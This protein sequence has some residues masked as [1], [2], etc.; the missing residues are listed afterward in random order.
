LSDDEFLTR[1]LQRM[2]EKSK[3]QQEPLLNQLEM[4]DAILAEA[5]S[6]I[7][8]LVNEMAHHEGAVLDVFR[9]EV[10][11]TSREISALEAE[12]E[13]LRVL[14]AQVEITAEQQEQLTAAL[15]FVRGRLPDSSYENKR[16]L[17]KALDA[18]VIVFFEGENKRIKVSCRLPG[19]EEDIELDTSRKRKHRSGSLKR[20]GAWPMVKMAG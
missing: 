15:E 5:H 11:T 17:L 10:K 20:C 1:G 14:L 4:V 7:E 8:R 9:R 2:M 12:R 16:Y 3:L 19:S 18:Q 6:K 13:R